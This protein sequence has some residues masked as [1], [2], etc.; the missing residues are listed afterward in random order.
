MTEDELKNIFKLAIDVGLAGMAG[1]V[2]MMR[3]LDRAGVL[4]KPAL[5]QIA[6]AINPH[7]RSAEVHAGRPMPGLVASREYLDRFTDDG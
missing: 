3:Q 7:I 2:E 5:T 4:D 1:T 6:A